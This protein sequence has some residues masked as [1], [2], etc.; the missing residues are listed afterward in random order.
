MS[1]QY[2]S[3]E[4]IRP[5]DLMAHKNSALEADR[6]FLLSNLERWEA[7]SC[8]VCSETFQ[9]DYGTKDE[10]VFVKCPTCSLVYMSPRP[11]AELLKEYYEQSQNYAF[12]NKHIFPVTAEIRYENIYKPRAQQLV[13][14]CQKYGI[15]SG[16]RFLEVGAGHGGFCDAVKEAGFFS[17]IVALEPT[18]GLAQTCRNKGHTVV[19][20]TAEEYTCSERYDVIVAYEVIEHLHNP[21]LF[22]QKVSNLLNPSGL[23]VLSFPNVDGFDVRVLK[24]HASCF[25]YGHLNYFN[26]ASISRLLFSQGFVALSI[27]TPGKMD[28][29]LVKKRIEDQQ[30]ERPVPFLSDFVEKAPEA[31]LAKFQTMLSQLGLSSHMVVIASKQTY[32]RNI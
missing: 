13:E 4:K 28:L 25:Q 24:T 9:M 14:V 15:P 18:A 7:V 31:E 22:I 8:S 30:L 29:D 19:E 2:L 12:W 17:Q 32:G 26:S 6:Q 20:S 1:K 5:A 11:S 10:C 21:T 3:V 23:L 27:T 16:G